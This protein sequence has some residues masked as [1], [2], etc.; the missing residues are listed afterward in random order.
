MLW[1]KLPLNSVRKPQ[2]ENQMCDLHGDVIVYQME[3]RY[4][5][6]LF[7]FPQKSG[8]WTHTQHE[9]QRIV[10]TAL[11]SVGQ[12]HEV[13][14]TEISLISARPFC[15]TK[16]QKS[17]SGLSAR[18]SLRN[19][20]RTRARGGEIKI[21]PTKS[22]PADSTK[23]WNVREASWQVKRGWRTARGEEQLDVKVQ[24]SCCGGWRLN[25]THPK[26]GSHR[27]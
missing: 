16:A 18:H 7:F 17:S 1:I 19:Q 11:K 9:K 8:A 22:T 23:V 6:H 14:S 27:E 10:H 5:L 25:W 20:V 13:F 3:Q 2:Y 12:V 4:V 21:I 24:M 15:Q 26:R